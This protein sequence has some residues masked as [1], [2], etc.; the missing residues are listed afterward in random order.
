MTCLSNAVVVIEVTLRHI[1]Y[2]KQA[3]IANTG[4]H[5]ELVGKPL[6]ALYPTQ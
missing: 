6:D 1:T 3:A 4:Y 2:V 5:K